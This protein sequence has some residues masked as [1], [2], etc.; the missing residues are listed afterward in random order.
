MDEN[1]DD[2]TKTEISENIDRKGSIGWAILGFLIPLVGFILFLVWNTKRP[3]DAQKAG[4]GAII[5]FIIG[6]IFL[7]I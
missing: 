5:G 1:L 6:I 3:G 4:I 2:Y 7:S